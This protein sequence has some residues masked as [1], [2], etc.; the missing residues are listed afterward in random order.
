MASKLNSEDIY[1][2]LEGE[3]VS[4]EILPSESI[5]ENGLC[6]RFDVS[7]TIIRSS[8]QR[9]A[10]NGFVEIIPHVG[11]IVTSIDMNTVNDFVY[12]RV[13]IEH[14]VLRDF[15]RSMTP[16]QVEEIRYHKNAFEKA[17]SEIDDF[18]TLDPENTNKLLQKDLA[19]HE[20]YFKYMNKNEIWQFLTQPQPNYSRFIRL[21]MLG[22]K[23]IPDVLE[24][25]NR[26]MDIIDNQDFDAI[27][28]AITRHL[29]GGI[30]RLS[31]KI[32]S[33]ELNKFIH[34]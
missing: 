22:G 25:H 26:I 7:R 31:S 21:D 32:F 8:L 18:I 29:Y 9:L 3:I 10:Q 15:M 16:D 27:E 12:M 14:A 33:D 5:S 2:I 1:K 11:T 6:A 24:E 28:D 23:N 20:C 19:F 4:L 34:K 13:A 17:V 30:R